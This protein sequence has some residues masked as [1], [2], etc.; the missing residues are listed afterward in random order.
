MTIVPQSCTSAMFGDL[1]A[2]LPAGVAVVTVGDGGTPKGL[3]VTSLT[4]YTANPPSIL[5]SVAHT[6]R[7]Y[8]SLLAASHFG[9]HV[10]QVGQDEVAGK[11]ASKDEDKFAG[12]DWEWDGDVPKVNGSLAY[13]KCETSKAFHHLDHT[14]LIGEIGDVD[15]DEAAEPMLYLRRRFAWRVS[16]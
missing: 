8:D 10:L 16:G 9:V 7:S 3:V 1:M 6:S 5:V 2:E 14:V 11:F 4:A 12:I 13:L 15:R